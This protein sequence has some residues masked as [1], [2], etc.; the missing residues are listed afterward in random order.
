[1]HNPKPVDFY[2]LRGLGR[3]SAHWGNFL[4]KLKKHK[5]VNKVICLDLPGTGIYYQ[6]QS[7]STIHE[8][9][10]FCMQNIVETGHD[11]II[12]AISLGGM[13]ALELL[14]DQKN[15]FKKAYIINSSIANLSPFYHR[16]QLSALRQ[17]Y[18]MA[19]SKN[20][21]EK[22]LECL[23]MVSRAE[24]SW[25]QLSE[26]FAQVAQE[27]PVHIL[28]IVKQLLA[29]SRY[30]VKKDKPHTPIILI[31][32]MGDSMVNPDC[33]LKLAEHWNLPLYTHPS[34]GHD[35][36]LDA[37]EWLIKILEESLFVDVVP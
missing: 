24:E 31:N 7:P 28:N 9:A 29:A 5:Y 27:R 3:E 12:L 1:M 16:L 26:N 33:S 23:K 18:K 25:E 37:P 4:E 35:L 8:I 22:E 17:F 11:K 13:V 34:A 6:E 21:K 36:P 19:I 30:K 20:L 10:Q 2:L 32:S 15:K 14:N